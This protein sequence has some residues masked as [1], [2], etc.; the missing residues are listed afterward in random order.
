VRDAGLALLGFVAERR[1]VTVGSVME[2]MGVE[3]GD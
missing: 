2:E 3:E 1:G